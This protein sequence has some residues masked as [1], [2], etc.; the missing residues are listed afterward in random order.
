MIG[1]RALVLF[2]LADFHAVVQ[3]ARLLVQ[4]ACTTK[5]AE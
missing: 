5:A 3:A 2:S 1:R 4:A